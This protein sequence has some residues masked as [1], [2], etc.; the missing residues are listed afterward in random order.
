MSIQEASAT[1]L[2]TMRNV[3]CFS[4]HMSC[5]PG[6]PEPS[7][8]KRTDRIVVHSS[9]LVLCIFIFILFRPHSF[10]FLSL[11]LF[12]QYSF[13]YHLCYFHLFLYSS[14]FP[15]PLYVF[16]LPFLTASFNFS[17]L[18]TYSFLCKI[19]FF[20]FFVLFSNSFTNTP[21]LSICLFFRSFI[22]FF[23]SF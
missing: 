17:F 11:F 8:L 7:P 12:F 2:S 9:L 15:C 20:M 1:S 10:I 16:I 23:L 22:S 4:I 14:F 21:Q 5:P 6:N 18:P 19:P 13:L 3:F